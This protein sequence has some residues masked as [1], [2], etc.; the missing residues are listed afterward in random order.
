MNSVSVKLARSELSRGFKGFWIYLACLALGT[1]AIA[2][3]GSVTETFSRGVASEARTLLGADAQFTTSQRRPAAEER[4]FAESLGAV[5]ETVSLDV[6]G[7]AK[8]VRAQV[9][10]RAVDGDYPLIGDAVLSGGETDLQAALARRGDRWGVVVTQ[11]FLDT[12][13]VAVGDAVD[14]GPVAGVVTARLDLSPDRIGTPGT[15]G[16]EAMVALDAMV[17]AERLTPGQ[18][19][20][21]SLRILFKPGQTFAAAEVTFNTSFPDEGTR[22]R[23][24][25]DAVDGLQ[26]LLQ[27]LNSFLA[28]IGI[29]A[30]VAGGVGVAQ[31]TAAFLDSRRQSIAVLK[32]FGADAATIRTAYLLQLGV[33]AIVGALAGTALGAAAPYLLAAFAGGAIPIPQAL[34]LYPAALFKA[35]T[36]GMLAAAVFALPAIGQARATRPASLFRR[37]GDAERNSAPWL[38]RVWAIGAAGALAGL[39]VATSYRPALTAMI[40]VGAIV[41]AGVFVAAAALVKWLAQAAS[42]SAR[43][44]WRLALANLGGPGSLAPTIV[45]SLGLGLA[46]LVLVVSV[47]TNLIRQITATAPANAPSLVFSQ[48]PNAKVGDFNS[49]LT[50]NGIDTENPDRYRQAPFLLARVT[51]LKG[52]PLVEA[53][54]AESE[55]WVVRGETSVTYFG[56]P[57]PD[58]VLVAGSWWAA[59]YAGPLLVSVEADAAKG[60]G[61][62]VGDTVGFRIAGRDVTATVTSLRKVDWGTFGIGSN[63]AFILS[64]GTL[65]AANPA[66]VA[67]AKATPEQESAI[68]AALGTDL[69]EVVVFQTRPALETAA[70]LFGQIA[71]A[72][73]GAA[74][75]VTLAGLL[76]LLGTFASLARKRRREAALLKVFGASRSEILRLYATEF[77]VAAGIAALVGTLI[78]VGAS[79]PIVT[80]VFEATWT[81]PWQPASAVILAAISVSAIGGAIVGVSTLS[82]TPADVLRTP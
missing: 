61:V 73:N 13:G 26:N 33:L 60:L 24:P 17:D 75:I 68:I 29:A 19:F 82:R 37:I 64:P 58:T 54:V 47:Q 4:A 43:G 57:P 53:D 9:D 22:L 25:E 27:T 3:A 1:A 12:F 16:P 45:P 18:L 63:T 42:T 32:V 80:Y 77:A 44:F 11:S 36:L 76:V 59:D 74:G 52:K 79:W 39:A 66:Y 38:E 41:T 51:A 55:R 35:L 7:A 50:A 48:I 5:S 40:L 30:L 49:V 28:V 72:V 15:F 6:M 78:G 10:V 56:E 20:R 2:A 14:I 23:G 31:A 71:L 67:I 65:E 81:L 21:S 62:G 70:R 34:A 46:L 69:R 8:D